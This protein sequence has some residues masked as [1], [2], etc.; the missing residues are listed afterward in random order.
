MSHYCLDPVWEIPKQNKDVS[1]TPCEFRSYDSARKS[2][3]SSTIWLL[4]QQHKKPWTRCL[5]FQSAGLLPRGVTEEARFWLFVSY[6]LVVFTYLVFSVC[7]HPLFLLVFKPP[8]SDQ[9]QQW[10]PFVVT[11]SLWL[12]PCF[13][14]SKRPASSWIFLPYIWK[15]PFFEGMG[16]NIWRP[17]SKSYSTP[18]RSPWFWPFQGI[19]RGH[20]FHTMSPWWWLQDF[21][22]FFYFIFLS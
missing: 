22:D 6:T 17:F 10:H 1:F 2:F 9:C 15:K 7:G 18:A 11:A 3:F 20:T 19:K 8:V 13:G 4:P 16:K 12:L 14:N 5:V 21:Q